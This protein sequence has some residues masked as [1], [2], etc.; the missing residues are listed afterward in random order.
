MANVKQFEGNHS[1]TTGQESHQN[2]CKFVEQ[3]QSSHTWGRGAPPPSLRIPDPESERASERTGERHQRSSLAGCAQSIPAARRAAFARAAS[4]APRKRLLRSSWRA[5]SFSCAAGPFTPSRR[6]ARRQRRQRERRHGRRL[7][8]SSAGSR[9]G[10]TGSYSCSKRALPPL[11]PYRTRGS[12]GARA[13]RPAAA[14]AAPTIGEAGSWPPPEGGE[15]GEGQEEVRG[16]PRAGGGGE[17]A[18]RAAAAP[19]APQSHTLGSP[20]EAPPPHCPAI[21]SAL[22]IQETP[23]PGTPAAAVRSARPSGR[24]RGER[25]RCQAPPPP[26]AHGKALL[27]APPPRLAL[28][29]TPRATLVR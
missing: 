22:H 11:S 21:L 4:R 27:Q 16:P 17:Q 19:L 18:R 29:P 3:K 24:G 25:S 12:D 28:T 13:L 7:P 14:E 23:P 2:P 9:G 1:R 5:P 10:G 26:S 15:R 6:P 8:G 20:A